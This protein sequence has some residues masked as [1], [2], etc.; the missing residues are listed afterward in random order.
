MAV[1]IPHRDSRNF[2]RAWSAQLF[3]I[4]L[5]G[6]WSFPWAAP[7]GVISRFLTKNELNELA[8][9]LR[10]ESLVDGR[11]GKMTTGEPAALPFPAPDTAGQS[12]GTYA[13]LAFFGPAL[14]IRL[15]DP[16]FTGSA[17]AALVHA[18][19]RPVLASATIHN[20]PPNLPPPP[21]ISFRA[22]AAANMIYRP[23]PVGDSPYSFEWQIGEL[24]WLPPVKNK[25]RSA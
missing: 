20:V 9:G 7:L 16:L 19:P 1:L 13:D 8:H 24:H 10:K 22:A 12:E 23:L 5:R 25:K 17:A 11:D 18:F 15:P 4:G 6:A 21:T 3:A 14:D 2:L